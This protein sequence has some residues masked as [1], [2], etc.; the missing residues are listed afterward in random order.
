[1]GNETEVEVEMGSVSVGP[2]RTSLRAPCVILTLRFLAVLV[3]S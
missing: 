2:L 1:M 3:F